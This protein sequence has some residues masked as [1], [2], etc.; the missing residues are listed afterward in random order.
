MPKHQRMQGC[1]LAPCKAPAP[2]FGHAAT[3]TGIRN[4]HASGSSPGCLACSQDPPKASPRAAAQP[5]L[6]CHTG[7]ERQLLPLPCRHA[8]HVRSFHALKQCLT[9]R[10]RGVNSRLPACIG[11][12]LASARLMRASHLR[13]HALEGCSPPAQRPA[14]CLT[15]RLPLHVRATATSQPAVT[16]T[17]RR[18]ASR[19][20]MRPL[21]RPR[22]LR[23]RRCWVPLTQRGAPMQP[24][25]AVFGRLP[26]KQGQTLCTHTTAPCCHPA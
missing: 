10:V 20:A 3:A 16:D 22:S 2:C 18:R 25:R 9:S 17:L 12:P 14:L 8:S 26:S 1:G 6:S 5:S 21:S 23:L 19:P 7:G 4:R 15:A 11:S 13:T 24:T